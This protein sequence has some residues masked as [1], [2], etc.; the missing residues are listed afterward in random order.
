MY[1]MGD[2]VY[3]AKFNAVVM[4]VM[5]VVVVVVMVLLVIVVVVVVVCFAPWIG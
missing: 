4:E 1:D 3:V 5:A 2:S